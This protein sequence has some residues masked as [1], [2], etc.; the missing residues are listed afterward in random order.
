MRC[1]G[2]LFCCEKCQRQPLNCSSL[3]GFFSNSF[4]SHLGSSYCRSCRDFVDFKM[5]LFNC[6]LKNCFE[7]WVYSVRC[8]LSPLPNCAPRE[9]WNLTVL[10]FAKGPLPHSGKLWNTYFPK[11]LL[12]LWGFFSPSIISSFQGTCLQT[13]FLYFLNQIYPSAGFYQVCCTIL[14]V[15]PPQKLL[16]GGQVWHEKLRVYTEMWQHSQKGNS[17]TAVS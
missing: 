11:V 12:M 16:V 9:A 13:K 17:V 7:S 15:T 8:C 2:K 14:Q 10:P 4:L 1:L 6:C 3:E 5:F